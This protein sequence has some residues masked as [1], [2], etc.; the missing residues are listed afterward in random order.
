[1]LLTSSVPP[2]IGVACMYIQPQQRDLWQCAKDS[3]LPPAAAGCQALP[4][5]AAKSAPRNFFGGAKE[6]SRPQVIL[7][8]E[9]LHG[10]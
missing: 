7:N 1:M 8:E 10:L 5:G 9:A 6:A 4:L 3:G 2:L